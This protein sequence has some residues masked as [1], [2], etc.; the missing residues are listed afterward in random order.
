MV[1]VS[2][3]FDSRA[4]EAL[5]ML[6]TL[7]DKT[8][9]T[10]F[11]GGPLSRLYPTPGVT[12]LHWAQRGVVPPLRPFSFHNPHFIFVSTQH[13]N[14]IELA[15]QAIR[16][17]CVRGG[18]FKAIPEILSFLLL[19]LSPPPSLLSRWNWPKKRIF[20]FYFYSMSTRG[21]HLN[22]AL[23]LSTWTQTKVGSPRLSVILACGFLHQL[24]S[25]LGEL[26]WSRGK[27]RGGRRS[28]RHPIYTADASDWQV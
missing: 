7:S 4:T 23:F 2:N 15:Q 28:D 21:V 6:L 3:R 9:L 5:L 22:A 17:L 11:W 18:T 27:G 26:V 8:P 1:P 16:S 12:A 24:V 19:L 10:L 25:A 14:V 20:L 13:W